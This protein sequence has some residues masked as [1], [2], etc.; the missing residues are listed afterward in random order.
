MEEDSSEL[1][2]E[3]MAMLTRKFKKFFKKIKAGTRKK[4]PNKSKNT[5]RDQLVGCF[6]CG[7]MDH[8]IKIVP[9]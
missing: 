8:I 1:D 5:D 3:D 9:C 6:K 4:Q 7:K 2:E